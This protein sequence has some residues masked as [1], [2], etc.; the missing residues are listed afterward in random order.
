M[1][2]QLDAIER[3]VEACGLV[4]P[5][6]LTGAAYTEGLCLSVADPHR[7]AGAVARLREYLPIAQRFNALLVVGLL[8]GFAC[9]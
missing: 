2:G 5:S 1:L 9:G 4:V 3:A 8:Q 6:L 7:R